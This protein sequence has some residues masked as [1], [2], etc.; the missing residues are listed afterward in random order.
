VT[1]LDRA[2]HTGT[3]ASSTLSDSTVAGRAM[4][5]AADAAAQ[6]ALLPAFGAATKG[7]VPASGGG[8]TNYLRADGTFAVPPGGSGIAWSDPVTADLVP[9]TDGTRDV[10]TAVNRFAEGH[11]DAVYIGTTQLD[12]TTLAD[13]GADRI[14]GWDDSGGTTAYFAPGTGLSIT[15][16][17]LN[18]EVSLAGAEA[19]TNKTLT[20]P[21]ITL[22]VNAQTGTTYT[23]DLTDAHKK[24]TMANASANTLTIPTNASVAFPVGSVIGV[25]MLGA[26]ATTVD[27]DTGVTVNGV[28]GGGA[29]ISAQ[30]TGVTLTKLATDTWLMEGN[31]GTVA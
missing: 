13:P 18:A 28:S 17:D 1:L 23:L 2:N 19:L 31:H 4:I 21:K 22:S 16:T 9:D 29:A 3:Q 14:L 10:G 12:G 24:I 8:T 15:G 7:V 5:S 11:F 27:G 20:D 25:T 26:G 6:A 30:Y